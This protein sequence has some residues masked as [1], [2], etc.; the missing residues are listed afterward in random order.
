MPFGVWGWV[1]LA[2]ILIGASGTVAYKLRESGKDSVRIEQEKKLNIL[3][4]K[5][6]DAKTEALTAPD[7]FVDC[8]LRKYADPNYKCSSVR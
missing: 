8:E 3:K 4:D 1:A 7:D 6:N 5:T 2:V